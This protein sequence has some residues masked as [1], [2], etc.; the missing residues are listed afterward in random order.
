MNASD[1]TDE[2]PD[3]DG[4]D[5]NQTLRLAVQEDL[6]AEAARIGQHEARSF[7]SARLRE[8]RAGVA[9][10]TKVAV[11]WRT[12]SLMRNSLGA[13][14]LRHSFFCS[15]EIEEGRSIRFVCSDVELYDFQPQPTPPQGADCEES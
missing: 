7:T 11:R 15:L 2:N 3:L 6:K 1:I 14:V 5:K 9:S 10:D 4:D 8:R 12:A 13:N